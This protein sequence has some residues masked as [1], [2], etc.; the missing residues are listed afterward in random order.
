MKFLNS[1]YTKVF[2][3][4]GL[5]ICVLKAADPVNGD[6]LGYR[7]D[8][9][10]FEGQVFDLIVDAMDAIDKKYKVSR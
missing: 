7:I 9:K 6:E 1:R 5:D 3:H 10:E 4:N 2:E 8:C